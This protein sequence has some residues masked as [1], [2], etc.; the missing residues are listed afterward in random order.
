MNMFTKDKHIM[1]ES[2][3]H[4]LTLICVAPCIPY[5]ASNFLKPTNAH[6]IIFGTL[7]VSLHVSIHM[8][9]HQGTIRLFHIYYTIHTIL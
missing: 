1:K 4:L 2:R 5:T 9:H 8:D 7:Q 3:E 6:F